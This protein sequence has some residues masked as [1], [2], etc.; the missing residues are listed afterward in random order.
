MI[1]KL[2]EKLKLLKPEPKLNDRYLLWLKNGLDQANVDQKWY[3]KG[4]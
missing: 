2:L 4:R 3:L 1:R